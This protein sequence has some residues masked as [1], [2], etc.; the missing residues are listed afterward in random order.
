LRLEELSL[1][2]ERVADEKMRGEDEQ[3]NWGDQLGSDRD[4]KLEDEV[5]DKMR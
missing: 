2:V 5:V 1:K 3:T 4:T